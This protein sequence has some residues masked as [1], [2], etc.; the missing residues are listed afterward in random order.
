MSPDQSDLNLSPLNSVNLKVSVIVPAYNEERRI[1]PTLND[2]ISF[3]EK[4]KEQYE[5]IVVD[6]GS[7]DQTS[8]IVNA[9]RQNNPRVSL[10]KF[11]NN[12][13]KGFAVRAGMLKAQGQYLIFTDADGATPFQEI[14]RLEQALHNGADIAIGSRAIPSEDTQVSARFH[15]KYLGRIFNLMV[16]FILL[17]KV[18][19]TQCGFKLFKRNAADQ[20]FS[21]QQLEGFSFD[22]EVLYI[23]RKLGFVTVEVPVNWTNIAGSK[24]NVIIDGL[25]MFLDLIYIKL[26]HFKT[27]RPNPV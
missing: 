2:I 21:R 15:R 13:G 14:N 7:K 17:P 16:N 8:S 12:H 25:K 4:R 22:V 27:S 3:L 18:A 10:L 1:T 11:N 9:I 6:D 19:D 24:V 20:V 26:I 5:I 23:A